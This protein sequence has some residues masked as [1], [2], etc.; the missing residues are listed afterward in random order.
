MTA[1]NNALP[2]ATQTLT[3]K[4]WQAPAITTTDLVDGVV[5]DFYSQTLVATGVP[6]P[7]WT[8]TGTLPGG[9]TFD[10]P[11]GVISGTPT[12]PGTATFTVTAANGIGTDA[13]QS[14]SI[15]VW[16]ES[17]ISTLTLDDGAVGVAYTQTLVAVGITAP[18]WSVVTGALPDGLNLDPSTG[19]ISGDPTD[20]AIGTTGFTV[21]ASDGLGLIVTRALSITVWQPPSISTVSLP[22][23]TV[24]VA[25]DQTLAATGDP[26]PTWALTG[27]LPDGLVFNLT[28]G[29]ISGTPTALAAGTASFS[30]TAS[31]GFGTDATQ[32]LSITVRQAPAIT[33]TGVGDGVVG[34]YYIETLHVTGFP[35]PI[36]TL[37]G[38]L[39]DG[40]DFDAGAGVIFGTPTTPGSFDF[41]V[42]AAN[43]VGTDATQ[44]LS[45]VIRQ[46]P[47]I[48]TTSLDNGTVG[49]S[50]SQQLVATGDPAPVW[51]VLPGVLPDGLYLVP[52]TGSILGTPT[53][54]AIGTTTFSVTASNGIGADATQS[55][56]ITVDGPPEIKTLV[57]DDGEVGAAYTQTLVATGSPTPTWTL[58]GTLPDGLLLLPT[59]LVI[60]Y[61]S[62]AGTFNFSVIASNGVGSDASQALSI[63][64]APAPVPLSFTGS[65]AFDIPPQ[66]VGSPV[67][68]IDVSGAVS[69]G[70]SPYT[71]SAVGLPA[72]LGIDTVTGVIS[73]IPTAAGP[74][75]TAT[76]TVQ[77]ANGGTASI[78]I[79]FSTVTTPLA[80]VGNPGGS[81]QPPTVG[82]PITPIDLSGAVS[83][84]TGPFTYSATG[85][86]AGV[87]ISPGGVISGTPTTAGAAGPATVTVADSLGATASVVIDF[88]TVA[89]P[90]V[91]TGNPGGVIEPPAV[92]VPIKPI[93]VSGAV[94]GGTGPFTYSATGLPAG[95]TISTGGVISGTP[96]TAGA[97]GPATVT[98]ADSRGVTATVVIDFGTIA[99]PS[100]DTNVPGGSGSPTGSGSPGG[101]TNT[102]DPGSQPPGGK[103]PNTGG[104]SGSLPFIPLV[105]AVIGLKLLP[106][107]RQ[108]KRAA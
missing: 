80:I 78:T 6:T 12:A 99:P 79:N 85:L 89:A 41:T 43:G 29:A 54:A 67:T 9:L 40:L 4:V 90:L 106:R 8:L 38:N 50:Y 48:S 58:S 47:S 66:I 74:A 108:G 83:G 25:Y 18:T 19:V 57:L 103:L 75:G 44:I 20:A 28:T 31:N 98:V 33:T 21:A 69:G 96:T 39:P 65:S 61:P 35:Y 68:S 46:S 1:G 42:A 52:A 16:P 55:L 26:A 73:G 92:G 102:T 22:D 45:I 64:V 27:T 49:V 71:F 10:A 34:D 7:D 63:V 70:A 24:G 100:G 72:G 59:G 23:G 51:S 53:A 91:I 95:I 104:D 97:A 11:S 87:T 101:Q 36:W 14:L 37:T 107:G 88:G 105:L 86:P 2:D 76:I 62:V 60:G 77:D 84:G 15:R 30:V 13:T 81:I 17:S 56:S 94:S 93:D 82:V 3:I 32:P 5:G